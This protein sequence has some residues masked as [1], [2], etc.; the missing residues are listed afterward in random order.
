MMALDESFSVKFQ[1]G[2]KLIPYK[3]YCTLSI[4]IRHALQTCTHT[5]KKNFTTVSSTMQGCIQKFRLG[6]AIAIEPPEKLSDNDLET[7]LNIWNRKPR[8]ISI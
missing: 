4:S 1:Q 8:R 2:F 3:C 6:G 7:I 5:H